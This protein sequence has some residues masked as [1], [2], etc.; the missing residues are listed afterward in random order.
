MSGTHEMQELPRPDGFFK[1]IW[2][3][4]LF[5]IV[6]V[7]VTRNGKQTVLEIIVALAVAVVAAMTAGEIAAA[8]GASRGMQIF[9][10]VMMALIGRSL[11]VFLVRLSNK[12]VTDDEIYDQVADAIVE[13]VKKRLGRNK[14]DGP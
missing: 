11:I 8:W 14:G 10:V 6:G 3:I 13:W 9:V 2:Y 4:A 7:V 5:A 12:I 1:W